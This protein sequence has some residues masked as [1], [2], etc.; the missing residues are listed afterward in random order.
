M[1][2]NISFNYHSPA[3]FV[4]LGIVSMSYDANDASFDR[5]TSSS[6]NAFE[7]RTGNQSTLCVELVTPQEL[8]VGEV[9]LSNTPDSLTVQFKV[10]EG[11]LF[12]ETQLAV[13]SSLDGIPK[14]GPGIPVLGQFGYKSSHST[15]STEQTYSIAL[16]S[17]GV[18]PGSEITVAAHASLV[19]D[20]KEEEGA[21][22][23]GERFVEEGNP[24]SYFSYELDR[25]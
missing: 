14:V 4:L 5:I 6:G 24:A 2:M 18:S 17:L 10:Q 12:L 8:S 7:E 19:N 11:W 13:A 15:A 16:D 21:W 22:A 25:P 1:P 20:L 9:C 3:T 23:R